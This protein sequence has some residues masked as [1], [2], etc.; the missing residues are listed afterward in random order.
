MRKYLSIIIGVVVIALGIFIFKALSNAEDE[1]PKPADDFVLTVKTKSAELTAIPY[2]IEVTGTLQ[3]KDKIELFS[4]VQGV[5][6]PN[7]T[8]FKIGNYFLK[9]QNLIRIDNGEHLAQLKSSRSDLINQLAIMLPDME[10]DYPKAYKKWETYLKS[11]DINATV[12]KLPTPK[13]NAE[14]LFVSGKSI[15]KTYYSIKNLEERLSKYFIRAPFSGV[16]TESNVNTGTLVRSGQKLGEFIDNSGFELQLSVPASEYQFLK[17]NTKV[18]VTTI[19]ESQTF[20]GILSR[21]NG[22]IDQSTQSLTIVVELKDKQLKDGQYLKA[23]LIGKPLPN[24]LA[25]DNALVLENNTIYIV[26]DNKL[27]LQSIKIINYQGST[28]IV[29]GIE[30]GTVIVNQ[31]IAN[32]YP[33]MP[34]KIAE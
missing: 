4:E 32:A 15:Y 27:Q 8:A 9:G 19:D 31:T 2:N 14:K 18:S 30:N 16:V 12:P 6:L 20:T 21:I 7:S 1:K 11:I 34:I 3:A 28:A 13:T 17:E 33:G 23:K 10:L 22:K 29:E 26:K 5:L 25:I 24:V